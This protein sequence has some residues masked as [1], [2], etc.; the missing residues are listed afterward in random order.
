LAQRVAQGLPECSADTGAYCKARQRLPEAV[1]AGLTRRTGQQLL[2]DAPARWCWHGRDVKV[3]DGS[4]ASM[5]DTPAN[6]KAYP[7]MR[8]Q[9]PG[10]GF[11]ILRL[12]V[13]FSLA[14]GTVLES[15]FCSYQGKETS[16]LALFRSLHDSLQEGDV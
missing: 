15:P 10:L 16:E 7:Q 14:G 4:T 3:V 5:P 2:L 12:L 11:P 8:S 1:L 9:K 6:Q 13:F